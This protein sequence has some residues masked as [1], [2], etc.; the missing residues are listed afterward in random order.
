MEKHIT[1]ALED[2]L[3]RIERL[4]ILL[5]THEEQEVP[6]LLAIEGYQKLKNQYIEQLKELL[7]EFELK[8]E[9]FPKAA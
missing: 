8:V 6:D 9:I 4:N 3:N 1:S 7:E 5:H 2:I